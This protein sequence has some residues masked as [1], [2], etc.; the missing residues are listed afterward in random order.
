[1][2]KNEFQLRRKIKTQNEGFVFHHIVKSVCD[3]E[4]ER[5]SLRE[6]KSE[7]LFPYSGFFLISIQLK[8][9]TPSPKTN[10]VL[11]RTLDRTDFRPIP[12]PVSALYSPHNKSNEK[13]NP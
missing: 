2:R 5:E 8:T 3:R 13:N 6:V 9:K 12:S 11:A 4:R 1:M 7:F 10:A